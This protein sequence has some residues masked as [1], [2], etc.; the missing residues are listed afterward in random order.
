MTTADPSTSSDRPGSAD[1]TSRPGATLLGGWLLNRLKIGAKLNLGFG[2]YR[3]PAG[4]RLKL[5]STVI[6]TG[7]ACL[8]LDSTS[9]MSSRIQAMPSSQLDAEALLEDIHIAPQNHF[10]VN[11]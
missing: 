11:A 4:G 6:Q 2:V 10:A 1:D 3:M 8:L 5:F 7:N 9:R